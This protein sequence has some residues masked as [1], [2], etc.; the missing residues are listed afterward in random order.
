[1]CIVYSVGMP[2]KHFKCV[3]SIADDILLM[4]GAKVNPAI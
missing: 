4:P 1:M 3:N 2:T